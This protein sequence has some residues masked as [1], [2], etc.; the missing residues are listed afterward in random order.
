VIEELLIA[1]LQFGL[2]PVWIIAGFADYCCH[3]MTRIEHTTGLA[4]AGLHA[5]L[6]LVLILI[7]AAMHLVTGYLDIAYSTG[8]R[9]V[10]PPEQHVH[11][12][13]EILP[14]VATAMLVVLYWAPFAAIFNGEPASWMLTR[15]QPALPAG[16]LAAVAV[17]LLLAGL[18]IA[19]ELVRCARTQRA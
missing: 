17:G 13:M 10:S 19:E 12:Y 7:L 4:E 11:S 14:L 8:R 9:Y 15:R 6:V 2:F 3:R 18:A 1:L 16:A 5:S